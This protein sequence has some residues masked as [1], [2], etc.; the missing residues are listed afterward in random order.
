MDN[1]NV[2]LATHSDIS[3]QLGVAVQCAEQLQLDAYR[4]SKEA[5]KAVYNKQRALIGA[6][7]VRT[8]AS[9]LIAHAN[10]CAASASHAQA[11]ATE[12]Q[13]ETT[14]IASLLRALLSGVCSD[15]DGSVVELLPSVSIPFTSIY[16]GNDMNP[17]LDAI[18]AAAIAQNAALQQ[19]AALNAQMQ[20]QQ[21]ARE[22]A[23][24]EEERLKAELANLYGGPG[25]NA[26]YKNATNG[27]YA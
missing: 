1:L 12:L 5:E 15:Q 13:L 10:A 6:D 7:D 25:A 21:E 26:P 18:I 27:P 8:D 22:A 23:R 9:A 4:A 14:R 11:Y 3:A 2:L 20:A 19:I 24:R 17:I 16:K